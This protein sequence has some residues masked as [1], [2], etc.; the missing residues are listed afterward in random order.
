[1]IKLFVIK[2]ANKGSAVAKCERKDY[3]KE[4][5]HQLGDTYI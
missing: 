3:I 1:M 4:A 2:G 5:E